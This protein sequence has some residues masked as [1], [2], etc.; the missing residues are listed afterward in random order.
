MASANIKNVKQNISRMI[1][2]D[3]TEDEIDLYIAGL[4]LTVDDLQESKH[5]LER[6][7]AQT[8][9]GVIGGAVSGGNPMGIALGSGIAGQAH[10]LMKEAQGKK[11]PEP[12]ITRS[13]GA[14]GDVLLDA[15]SPVAL[16]K[17]IYL[18]KKVGAP[19]LSKVGKWVGKSKA[20]PQPPPLKTFTEIGVKPSPGT[21]TGKKSLQI[22]ENALS[23]FPFS[24]TP[25]QRS[26]QKNI[27]ELRTSLQ[28][29]AK[30]YGPVLS[31]E[32]MGVLLKSGAAKEIDRLSDPVVG[33]FE[34]LY[35]FL[36]REIGTDPQSVSNTTSMLK[37][38][39]KESESG[40]DSSIGMLAK[41]LV[42]KAKASGGGL[43]F[44]ALKKFRTKW[45]EMLKD[46]TLVS[47][48]N[49]QQ[50]DLK[51]L[52]GAITLDMEDAALKSGPKAHAKW[53]AVNKY[54]QTKMTRDVPILESIIK[55]GYPE[56]VQNVLM[57]SSA[58]GGSRLRLLRKQMSQREWDAVSGTVLG[59]MGYA[60]P[61]AQD[62]TGKAFSV[63]SFMTRWSKL[64]TPAKRALFK[65]G[66]YEPLAK[67]LDNFVKVAGSM[68]EV[69]KIANKSKTGSVLMF[70]SL[71]SQALSGGGIGAAAGGTTGAI[72]GAL[73]GMGFAI[74]APK[75]TA[76]LLMSPKFV[77]W[78]AGGIKIAKTKP[79]AMAVHLGR[80]MVLRHRENM[81]EDVDNII[82]G[83]LEK[84]E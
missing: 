24:A 82:R 65:G 60:T 12:L 55:K 69:Q 27:A 20:S 15:I 61:S 78:L 58:K 18:G 44:E 72:S 40:P 84:E 29:L 43:P 35:G 36:G 73:A 70:F 63:E 6:A 32:E 48:R 71:F 13:V 28:F 1:A 50:G 7:S 21:V 77:R 52:Y 66:R 62:Y 42:G 22:A 56:E 14:T 34:K 47:T 37:T 19:V 30:E 9:G 4:G 74:G 16:S 11:L 54:F 80:L 59:D 57:Q 33:V 41:E 39:I 81:R 75:I 8:V 17:G 53:R 76:K 45:G 68:K 51:R 79:D 26:A 2:Q 83:F 64:S 5:T 38:I 67:E 46:P 10:D 31:Q 49:I 3:A 23:D 25:I